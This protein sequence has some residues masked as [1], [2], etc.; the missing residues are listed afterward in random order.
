MDRDLCVD[1]GGVFL[2][3]KC[4]QCGA[5]SRDK[6]HSH[7]NDCP[8]T[9]QEVRDAWNTRTDATKDGLSWGGFDIKG[10]SKS[11]DEVKRLVHIGSQ[12]DDWR[13]EFDQRIATK[14]AEIARLEAENGRMRELL[15]SARRY[16][17][18]VRSSDIAGD[19]PIFGV[20]EEIDAALSP[21]PDP[22]GGMPVEVET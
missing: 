6:Y 11:L 1:G 22:A 12:L 20:M 19:D 3:I 4:R 8:Q 7:G 10:D 5:K 16:V 17:G 18:L 21:T 15:A 9:Y 14:D 2:S 13:A